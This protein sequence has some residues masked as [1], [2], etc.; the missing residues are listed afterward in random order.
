[1]LRAAFRCEDPVLSL[2]HKHLL[3]QPYARDPFPPPDYVIPLGTAA[4]DRAG[5]D[6]TIVTYGATIELSR[7]AAHMLES[8][9]SIEIIDLRCLTPWIRNS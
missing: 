4:V 9:A 7:R 3:R 5:T 1:M 2:E 6:L 8:E